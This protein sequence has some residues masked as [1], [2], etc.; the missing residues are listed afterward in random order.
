M[1]RATLHI[2]LFL[3]V[4]VSTELSVFSKQEE[5][6]P[7]EQ[8]ASENIWVFCD[9]KSDIFI[10]AQPLPGEKC[11]KFMQRLLNIEGSCKKI[12]RYLSE[13]DKESG[14]SFQFPLSV[15]SPRIRRMVLKDVFP[16]D[17]WHGNEYVH[18][19]VFEWGEKPG[20]TLWK[21]AKWFTGDSRNF[22]MIRTY[23]S[24]ESDVLEKGVKIRIPNHLVSGFLW[25]GWQHASYE[26]DDLKFVEDAKGKYAAYRLKKGEAL[27][28]SVILKYTDR[29]N[30]DDVMEAA[31]IIKKRS[32]IEDVKNIPIGYEIK[33]PVDLISYRYL[34]PSFSDRIRYERMK[35]ES[36]RY[37]KNVFSK[38]L[39]E[40]VILLD[41]GHGGPDPGA[42]GVCG[43]C[44]D[45]YAY[46]LMCRIKGC[47]ERNSKARVVPLV[48]D[49]VSEYRIR[50]LEELAQDHSEFILSVPPYSGDD[51]T[52]AVN[53]RW[54]L[55]NQLYDDLIRQNYDSEKIVFVSIHADSRH[56]SS[57]GAMLYVPGA[58]LRAKK[59]KGN[60]ESYRNFKLTKKS[61][62]KKIKREESLKS[63]RLSLDFAE[64]VKNSFLRWNIHMHDPRPIR[65][66]VIRKGK[67]WLPAVLKYNRIPT[68]ILLETVNLRNQQD[69]RKMKCPDY[70]NK[71]AEAFTE[72]L[73]NY[74]EESK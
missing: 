22:E 30:Y 19:L 23:N 60:T 26:I 3:T 36:L 25:P 38:N 59:W 52:I 14:L 9:E 69:C 10:K 39:K 67:R 4:C 61:Y 11:S 46:D 29:I 70:R 48:K 50:Q 8:L 5:I 28:S 73:I 15:T 57:Y 32:A 62:N 47:I 56:P 6:T 54:M 2:F 65:D 72:A 45:E 41:A 74:F 18:E 35:N 1:M 64:E 20:E 66:S 49:W 43:I 31:E 21:I 53:L 33:I 71:M 40:V 58:M 51:T 16:R 42:V 27:Y 17:Y 63:Q 68:A 55:A 44:E 12:K 37:R 24:L 7:G 13:K 34:P